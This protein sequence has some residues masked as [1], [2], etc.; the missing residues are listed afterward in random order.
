M[1]LRQLQELPEFFGGV[2]LSADRD[3]QATLCGKLRERTAQEV[4]FLASGNGLLHFGQLLLAA[5]KPQGNC[6]HRSVSA[7]M[8]VLPTN[9][10]RQTSR[11][12]FA[13]Q[14]YLSG[15][16]IGLG[17]FDHERARLL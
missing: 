7:Q 5:T 16:G 11:R 1:L 9:I 12:R 13:R 10:E 17:H 8:L 14:A 15:D 6:D 2:G 3:V 4:V